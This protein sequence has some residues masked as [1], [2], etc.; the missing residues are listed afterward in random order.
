MLTNLRIVS[1]IEDVLEGGWNLEDL[2][3]AWNEFL[4]RLIGFL[5]QLL[6][7]AVILLAVVAVDHWAPDGLLAWVAPVAFFAVTLVHT[8]I[9]VARKTYVVDMADASCI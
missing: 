7:A 5:P 2:N 1:T 6:V 3:T 8:G 9:R 4:K